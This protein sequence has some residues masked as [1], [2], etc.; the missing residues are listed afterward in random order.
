MGAVAACPDGQVAIGTEDAKP[1]REVVLAK[2]S[3]NII[4]FNLTTVVIS[5][6]TDM[7]D[8]EEFLVTFGATIALH[9]SARIMEQAL[10]TGLAMAFGRPL[11][12]AIPA[13]AGQAVFPTV[14]AVKIIFASILSLL[15][16]ETTFLH[17]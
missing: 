7:V 4:G 16:P 13:L 9:Q 5:S 15:A 8:L 2:P 17:Q 1:L 10:G 14:V 3:I 6:P 11:V 12:F